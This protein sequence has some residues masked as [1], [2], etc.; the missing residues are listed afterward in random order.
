MFNHRFRAAALGAA[1]LI[2]CL[3]CL[4]PAAR[5]QSGVEKKLTVGVFN[6]VYVVQ[7]YYRSGAW[8]AKLQELMNARNAAAI[9]S[10]SLKVEQLDKQLAALQ[11]LAQE[12]LA[13][14]APLTNIYDALKGEWPAIAREA[15]VDVIVE[16]P[17][18]LV[19][20]SVLV[21]VTSTVVK[22]LNKGG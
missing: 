4:P 13:G 20:G 11:T 8:R 16:P 10:D 14:T 21:D 17:L 15:N 3:A 6:R 12:Q 2:A 18:Y 19:P 5:A 1:A 22:H 7:T 9:S